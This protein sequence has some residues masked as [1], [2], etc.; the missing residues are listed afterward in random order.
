MSKSVMAECLEEAS[1]LLTVFVEHQEQ[2][3]FHSYHTFVHLRDIVS[4]A[5]ALYQER[6]LL[7]HNKAEAARWD[8]FSPCQPPGPLTTPALDAEFKSIVA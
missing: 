7:A 8:R 2:E 3:K 4:L 6:M 1:A 5:S